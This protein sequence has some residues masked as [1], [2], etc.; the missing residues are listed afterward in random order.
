MSLLFLTDCKRAAQWGEKKSLA[1]NGLSEGHQVA[2]T[3]SSASLLGKMSAW[4]HP[5]HGSDSL[6]NHCLWLSTAD[7]QAAQVPNPQST[8]PESATGSHTHT[9]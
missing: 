5:D 1:R 4:A 7:P 3:H 9:E 6:V 8:S 2:H